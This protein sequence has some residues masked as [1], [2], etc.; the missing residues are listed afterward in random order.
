MNNSLTYY[1]DK[2]ITPD[3]TD[4]NNLLISAV[5]LEKRIYTGLGFLLIFISC[6][7]IFN[8]MV[9]ILIEKHKQ[10]YF[11]NIMG[12]SARKGLKI[13]LIQNMLMS[14]ILTT[15]GYFLSELTIYLN[16]ENNFFSILFDFLPFKILPMNIDIYS[17]VLLFILTN[18]VIILSSTLPFLIRKKIQ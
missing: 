14:F 5:S 17:A 11:I 1:D 12:L 13:I 2:F 3:M 9:M 6:I 18:F 7:M 16:Y 8:V 10:F 15:L 4:D